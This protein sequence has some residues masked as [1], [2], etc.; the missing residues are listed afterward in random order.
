MHPRSP[1]GVAKLYGLWIVRNYRESYNMFACN[2][3][4]FNHE[5]PVRGETFVTRK[6]TRAI[7]QISLGQLNTLYLWN[8]DALRDWWHAKD[9]I[10]GMWLM[11]QQDTPQDYVL[12]TGKAYSVRQFVEF[13][14]AEAGI[15]IEWKG[16]WVDEKWYNK[17]T[18][19]CIVAVDPRYFR[20]A[21]VD[22][23]LGDSTKAQQELW[24]HHEYTLEA[25]CREMVQED[26]K[27]FKQQQILKEHGYDILAQYE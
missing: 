7:A 22:F 16:S 17:L 5:S 26:I 11:L 3:I 27:H 21:E 24:W 10:K 1:Y 18:W 8:L 19:D 23:L 6:I 25:M 2:G 4:L 20:P 12:A 9:Y 15:Q 14:C 13:S